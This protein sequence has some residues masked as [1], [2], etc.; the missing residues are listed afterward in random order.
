MSRA[1]RIKI[2]DWAPKRVANSYQAV[3]TIWDPCRSQGSHHDLNEANASLVA[4]RDLLGLQWCESP[5]KLTFTIFRL[6]YCYFLFAFRMVSEFFHSASLCKELVDGILGRL[7][8]AGLVSANPKKLQKWELAGS[9]LET[10]LKQNFW[11]TVQL[12]ISACALRTPQLMGNKIDDINIECDL[13][14]LCMLRS[15]ALALVF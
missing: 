2:R 14:R 8:L 15:H 3:P 13:Q 5:S 9:N 1:M 6:N 10:C 4:F 12:M 11:N 7:C